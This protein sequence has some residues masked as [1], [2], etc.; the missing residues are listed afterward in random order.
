M[1][2][3]FAPPPEFRYSISMNGQDAN[4]TATRKKWKDDIEVYEKAKELKE[5]RLLSLNPA[6]PLSRWDFQLL[7]NIQFEYV[8]N[9]FPN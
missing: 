7:R 9:F 1:L 2:K 8:K 3:T 5:Q 6:R 4:Q